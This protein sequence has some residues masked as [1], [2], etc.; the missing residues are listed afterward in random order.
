MLHLV[1]LLIKYICGKSN[2]TLPVT[3]YFCIIGFEKLKHE[4]DV[5]L[6]N[7]LMMRLVFFDPSDFNFYSTFKILFRCTI[8]NLNKV[9]KDEEKKCI[10]TLIIHKEIYIERVNKDSFYLRQLNTNR[11]KCNIYRLYEVL[12]LQKVKELTVE[13]EVI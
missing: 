8:E 11:M 4:V 1:S 10:R 5:F 2:R 6:S 7:P 13:W 3:Y 12:T 9:T